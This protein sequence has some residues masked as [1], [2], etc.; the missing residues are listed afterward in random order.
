MKFNTVSLLV[1]AVL[2]QQLMNEPVAADVEPAEVVKK[3]KCPFGF[4]SS[5]SEPRKLQEN[6]RY[7]SDIFKCSGT[8]VQ[9]TSVEQ[10]SGDDYEAIVDSV[11]SGYE[12]SSN[13]TQYAACLLRFAGHD[14]MDYRKAQGGGSDGCVDFSD[15][16]NKGLQECL[17]DAGI[18]DV[19]AQNCD[20]VSLADFVVIAAEAAMGRTSPDYNSANRFAEDTLL[21]TFKENFLVGR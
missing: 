17:T 20:K 13:P 5:S 11:I 18:P 4:S 9:K 7:P 8:A 1:S 21:D 3:S 6:V 14:F 2:G 12:K 19:Y 15:A 10:F 16:D